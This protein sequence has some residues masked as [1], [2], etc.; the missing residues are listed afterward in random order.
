MYPGLDIRRRFVK[1][2]SA[3]AT[4]LLVESQSTSLPRAEYV[5]V[6]R[7][8]IHSCR[9]IERY[10]AHDRRRRKGSL[11]C[12]TRL[13][14][15]RMATFFAWFLQPQKLSP[16]PGTGDQPNRFNEATLDALMEQYRTRG[17]DIQSGLIAGGAIEKLYILDLR[18]DRLMSGRGGL[19][20]NTTTSKTN[21]VAIRHVAKD[22]CPGDGPILSLPQ[23]GLINC[24]PKWRSL[25]RRVVDRVDRV[26]QYVPTV[27]T[28]LA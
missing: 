5:V 27:K 9:G 2:L 18:R 26:N 14:M 1:R 17:H 4:A 19:E 23:C 15:L 25:L 11:D 6:R 12:R 8:P 7:R 13:G 3:G 28:V 10:S 20:P 22:G 21:Q 24:R 16:D